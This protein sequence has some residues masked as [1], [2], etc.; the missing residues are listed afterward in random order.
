MPPQLIFGTASFGM[1]LTDFQDAA[2]VQKL[3]KCLQEIGIRR[4]DSGARY[5]PTNPGRS[6]DLTE[7]TNA[8]SGNFVIDTKV[9]TDVRT[10]GSGG[11]MTQA[12]RK[13]L[14][15]SLQRLRSNDVSL[16]HFGHFL[17]IL[18]DGYLF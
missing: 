12:I 5:P 3:L 13:S 10:D 15:S 11:L 2:S 14:A 6:E 8:L 4:L 17:S 1:D 18:H 16:S 7:E 9:Y